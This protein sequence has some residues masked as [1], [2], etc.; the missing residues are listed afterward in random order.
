MNKVFIYLCL[1]VLLCTVNLAQASIA[2]IF[3]GVSHAAV[4]GTKAGMANGAAQ[5]GSS[6]AIFIAAGFGALL[7][8]AL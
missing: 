8:L 2:S 6:P 5:A 3:S 1:L 7:L 4:A